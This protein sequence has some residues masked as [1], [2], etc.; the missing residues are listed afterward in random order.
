MAKAYTGARKSA[1]LSTESIVT[2]PRNPRLHDEKQLAG[3]VESLQHFG[4]A[5]PLLV[6]E[7]D[8]MLVAGH[9]VLEAAKRA[10]LT[11]VDVILWS[12]S[13]KQ[14][15]E[16]MIADNRH[17]DRSR[18]DID[19][20]AALFRD[21]EPDN[22]LALGFEADEVAKLM[23]DVEDDPLTVSEIPTAMVEDRFWISVTGP[24]ESQALALQRLQEVMAEV[25]GIEVQLGTMEQL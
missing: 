12:V 23:A 10:G 11:E 9:G 14:A 6:R 17:H 2:N 15:D 4:Q 5:R 21:L 1:R 25:A 20:I 16:F 22:Y 3:L 19:R 7:E 13:R 8:R 18:D 24:L